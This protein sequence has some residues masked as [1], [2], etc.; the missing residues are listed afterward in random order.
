M[1]VQE[2]ALCGVM[3][4][5][6]PEFSSG[7]SYFELQTHISERG[8]VLYGRLCGKSDGKEDA[9]KAAIPKGFKIE[10]L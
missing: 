7:Y 9:V 10:K 8:I 1:I 5:P 3:Q 4:Y 6:V 2:Y